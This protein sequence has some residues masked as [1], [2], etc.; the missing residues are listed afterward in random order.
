MPI[1]KSAKKKLRADKKRK[2]FNRKLANILNSSI[3]NAEKLPSQK[4]IQE[5]ISIVDKSAKK[6]IIHKNKA[7][8]LKSKLSKLLIKKR[9]LTQ[10]KQKNMTTKTKESKK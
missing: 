10:K 5:A 3:K 9:D 8:R 4:N 1:V 7:S 6:N 2:A